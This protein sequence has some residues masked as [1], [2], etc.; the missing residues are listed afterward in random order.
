MKNLAGINVAII[1]P[2]FNEAL[3]IQKVITDFRQ[4]LPEASIFIFDNNS[5]DDTVQIA[6]ESGV[7]VYSVKQQGKGNVVRRMFAD[8]DADIYVMVDGDATYDAFSCNLLINKLVSENLDMVVGSRV[9]GMKEAYRTGHTFGNKLLTGCVKRIFGGEFSDMLS[10]YRVFS[11]RYVKSFPAL[12][13][14]FETET[15]LTV[16]AYGC[17]MP[18]LILHI[19]LVWKALPVNCQL[20][21]MERRF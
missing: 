18:K 16:H 6:K 14:G 10:G 8:V 2:C 17:H 5:T 4:V 9:H 12:S 3:S 13:K 20:I 15:E 21:K 7:Q 1:V 11:K 19:V